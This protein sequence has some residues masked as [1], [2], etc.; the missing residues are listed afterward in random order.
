MGGRFALLGYPRLASVAA[1][2]LVHLEVNL[3]AVLAI[4][5]VFSYIP[6]IPCFHI[7]MQP[8]NDDE[9]CG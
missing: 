3:L 4:V 8:L 5:Y 6:S 9:I 7:N 1:T 2:E